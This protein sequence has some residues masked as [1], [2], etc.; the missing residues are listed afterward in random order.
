MTTARRSL[1]T[2]PQATARIRAAQADLL[3]T[4]PGIQMPDV[5][6]LRAQ[7]VLGPQPA[8]TSRGRRRALGAGGHT[9]SP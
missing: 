8:P 7:G 1:G 9:D 6:E 5:E 4:L 2:G 3:A